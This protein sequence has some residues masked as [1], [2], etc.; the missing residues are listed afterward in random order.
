MP[1]SNETE[2]DP[3]TIMI[4]AH[5]R[6]SLNSVGRDITIMLD[7][8]NLLSENILVCGNVYTSHRD[9]NGQAIEPD[10]LT[11]VT[12]FQRST[13]SEWVEYLEK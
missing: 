1:L 12:I 5:I 9:E 2:P 13:R 8:N 3:R 6:V 7:D 10:D 11:R 4:K